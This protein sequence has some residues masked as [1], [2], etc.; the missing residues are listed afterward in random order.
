MNPEY[1]FI[2]MIYIPTFVLLGLRYT[3]GGYNNN[4]NKKS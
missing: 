3:T 2:K 4:K 1:P